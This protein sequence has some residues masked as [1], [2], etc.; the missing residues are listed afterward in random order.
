MSTWRF[1]QRFTCSFVEKYI[2]WRYIGGKYAWCTA[3]RSASIMEFGLCYVSFRWILCIYGSLCI[4]H[5]FLKARDR[6]LLSKI[7]DWVEVKLDK[8]WIY[9]ELAVILF[10]TYCR[11]Y[12]HYYHHHH[13]HTHTYKFIFSFHA[14]ILYQHNKCFTFQLKDRLIDGLLNWQIK[15]RE[16]RHVLS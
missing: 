1:S 13:T 2:Y 15:R 9:K 5:A 3:R 12:H 11:H 16:S 10:V 6:S 4:W 7:F 14:Q 8:H